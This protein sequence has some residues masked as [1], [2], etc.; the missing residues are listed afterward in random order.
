MVDLIMTHPGE[1]TL[2]PVAPLT[3]I[4]LALALEPGIVDHVAEVV[5]MGG[6]AGVSGNVNPAAEAN[7]WHDPHAAD[8]VFTAGWPVTIAA[9]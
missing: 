9:L 5:L 6:A 3:N 4:A 2:A 1:I 8:R 7:I